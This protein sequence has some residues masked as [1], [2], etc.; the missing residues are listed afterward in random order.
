[1]TFLTHSYPQHPQHPHPAITPSRHI[2]PPRTHPSPH[3]RRQYSASAALTCFTQPAS[4]GPSARSASRSCVADSASTSPA[5]RLPSAR[6]RRRERRGA[7]RWSSVNWGAA[8]VGGSWPCGRKG[9]RE[10]GGGRQADVSSGRG[11]A[12]QNAVHRC[13]A[14]GAATAMHAAMPPNPSTYPPTP[15]RPHPGPLSPL[16]RVAH[17]QVLRLS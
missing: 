8:G 12:P 14:A 1:M 5:G 10:A 7:S 13:S 11:A 6:P 2:P 15:N 3:Q 16:L 17:L 9:W 4:S